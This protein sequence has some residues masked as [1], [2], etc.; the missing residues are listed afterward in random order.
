VSVVL[1]VEFGRFGGVMGCVVGV[2]LRRVGVVGG[3]LV[4]T[5]LMMPG[6]F[7]MVLRR[8][9]VVFRCLNMVLCCLF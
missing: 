8:V 6:G 2:P 9:L 4:V 7:Q 3:C 1:N 5:R